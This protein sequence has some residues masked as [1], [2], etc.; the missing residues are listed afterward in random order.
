MSCRRTKAAAV[1]G[2]L[3]QWLA[4]H[5]RQ[6]QPTLRGPRTACHVGQHF[7]RDLD[8]LACRSAAESGCHVRVDVVLH[9]QTGPLKDLH[10]QAI[11]TGARD[12]DDPIR[13]WTCA[14]DSN[15]A[16]LLVG[17]VPAERPGTATAC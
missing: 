11:R 7:A 4:V 13:S 2:Y 8:D 1:V 5:A 10:R 15:L 6:R 3:E 9:G 17:S 14:C 16:E 12:L